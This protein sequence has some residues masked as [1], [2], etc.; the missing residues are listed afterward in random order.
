MQGDTVLKRALQYMEQN[1]M[2]SISF[3]DLESIT[4]VSRFTLSR[5]FNR[6]F[7][8]SPIRWLWAYRVKMA[9]F[10]LAS[11]PSWSCTEVAYQCG[12]E[13]PGHF[14]RRF[15]G[16]YGRPPGHFRAHLKND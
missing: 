3:D 1:Y 11:R 9:A 10:L 8:V 6:K 12:F 14:N 4:G 5:S 7:G 15:R 13:T 2:E 16:A